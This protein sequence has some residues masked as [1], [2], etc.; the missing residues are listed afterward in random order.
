MSDKLNEIKSWIKVLIILNGFNIHFNSYN[1]ND[2][3]NR[4][5][6]SILSELL[7]TNWNY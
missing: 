3:V 6:V 2:R 5:D 1:L 7:V 4:T